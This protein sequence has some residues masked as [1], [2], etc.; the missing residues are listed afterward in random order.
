M[1]WPV[2]IPAFFYLRYRINLYTMSLDKQKL[3]TIILC[4]ETDFSF[5]NE[6]SIK[7]RNF[8]V[9]VMTRYPEKD[10]LSI[11]SIN[12]LIVFYKPD[13][14]SLLT[15]IFIL[16]NFLP[17]ILKILSRVDLEADSFM[18]FSSLSVL[19]YS[20]KLTNTRMEKRLTMQWMCL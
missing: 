19:S 3:K 18:F 5:L 13:D 10:F 15:G 7:S 8:Q 6:I 2:F 1:L 17:V 4:H 16:R 12:R 11:S 20:E 9:K 14:I